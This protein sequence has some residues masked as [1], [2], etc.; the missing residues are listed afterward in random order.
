MPLRDDGGDVALV[1]PMTIAE[2]S[3]VREPI[4]DLARATTTALSREGIIASAGPR[5]A[6]RLAFPAKLA[7]RLMQGLFPVM[8]YPD[9]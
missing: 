2:S 6:W 7:A 5:D 4:A 3:R 9:R 8:N 1:E